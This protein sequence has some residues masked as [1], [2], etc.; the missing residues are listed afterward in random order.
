MATRLNW[1]KAR[2]PK[3][4]ARLKQTGRVVPKVWRDDLSRRATLELEKWMRRL[5]PRNRKRVR[6]AR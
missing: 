4:G 3:A 2:Q 6:Y 1:S 5:S